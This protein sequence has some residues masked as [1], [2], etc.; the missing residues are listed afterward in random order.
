M[1]YGADGS[2]E[3]MAG[4]PWSGLLRS[5]ES[6]E[7]EAPPDG[8]AAPSL[9][10]MPADVLWHG[11]PMTQVPLEWSGTLTGS[12]KPIALTVSQYDCLMTLRYR[13]TIRVVPPAAAN[14]APVNGV[15]GY[16][17]RTVNGLL[18]H[19]LIRQLPGGRYGITDNGLHALH[20]NRVRR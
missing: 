20:A 1:S 14:D 10:P 5:D 16:T 4:N 15:F 7:G 17:H 2:D 11:Q 9:K 3:L 18:R 8:G 12:A 6:G 13:F 19:G